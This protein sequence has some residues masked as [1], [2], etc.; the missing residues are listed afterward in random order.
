MDAKDLIQVALERVKAAVD[1]TTN[2]LTYQEVS[3][4]PG[5]E[6]NC[7]GLILLHMARSEDNFINTRIQNGTAVWD[8][9]K[10]YEK[11]GLLAGETA[12]SGYGREQIVSFC[13]PQ[14]KET[15]AYMEAVRKRTLEFLKDAQLDKTI[16]LPRL[17]DLST[18]AIFALIITHLSQHVGE[19]SY[20]RGMQRGLNG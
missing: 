13:S 11:L 6:S 20:I 1:R 12:G 5:P 18:G 4:R 3:W 8:S 10:W 7:I 19:I 17:G 2:G 9:G 14:L 16:N 15:I